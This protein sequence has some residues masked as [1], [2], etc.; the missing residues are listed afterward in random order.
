[1]TGHV[2]SSS[3][4]RNRPA[5]Q[6]R[7][8]RY[9]PF[10]VA[11]HRFVI[12]TDVPE[13]GE[14]A[15]EALHDLLAHGSTGDAAVVYEVARTSPAWTTHPWGV[16]RDGEPCQTQLADWYV[17]PYLVWE[18]TSLLLAGVG[19]R[20]ALHAGAAALGD[21][22]VVLAGRSHSGKSTLSGWLT[23]RGWSFLTD[24]VAVIDPTSL[25]VQP[26]WRPIGVRR[27][28]PLSAI[29]GPRDADEWLVPA[30]HFGRLA[31]PSRLR[32]FLLASYRPGSSTALR[33]M[34][35]AEATVELLQSVPGLR[36]AGR[37]R[38]LGVAHLVERTAVYALEVDDLDV[39][40]R[41]IR[42]LI[43][44]EHS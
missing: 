25:V 22:A 8:T 16:W 11:G 26:F 40:E 43:E 27:G 23:H 6:S 13:L 31:G 12:D 36:Q 17:L 37:S 21:R 24:E 30:S 10:A 33:R 5:W 41:E 28:G 34:S 18:L 7:S 9:G 1:M 2:G 4:R 15:T 32:A 39:A 38:F 44:D 19:D 3:R 29:A 35:S 14:R 20:V 42:A